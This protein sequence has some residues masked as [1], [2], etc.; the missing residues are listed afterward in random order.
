MS[1]KILVCDAIHRDGIDLMKKAGLD[2]K[3]AYDIT[4]EGLEKEVSQYDA[5]VVRGRTK[6]T[7]KVIEAGTKLRAVARSG[8]GLDNIDLETAKKKAIKVIS[9][10]AAPTTSVAELTIGLTLSVLRKI[11]FADRA[12]KDGKWAK[13]ELMGTELRGK[14]V[15]VVGVVGRIGLEV[16]R[17]MIQGFGA[18][19]VGYDVLDMNEQSKQLGFRPVTDVSEVLKEADVITIHVP[20]L[21]S[22]HHLIDQKAM[23]TMKKNAIIINPSRGDIIDGQALLL[24]LKEGRLGGAGLDVFHKEP[25]V[26]DWEKQ[27]VS[28]PTVV[29]TSHIGAQTVECQRLES[30]MVAEQLIDALK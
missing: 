4:A 2:V 19:V 9:T 18:K 20:Y 8:V 21:K 27:L 22:T 12:M 10:P 3:E 13:S 11:S 29:C 28:L 16:A 1:P 17:I 15:G 6:V 7:G 25:P 26:D 5:L 23:G 24:A 14:T 30:T